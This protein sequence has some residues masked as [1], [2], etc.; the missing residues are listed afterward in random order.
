MKKEHLP[1]NAKRVFTGV[2]FDVYQWD[3]K[4]YDGSTKPFEVVA[5]RDTVV[6]IPVIGNKILIQHEQ[7]PQREETVIAPPGGRRDEDEEPLA[8]AKRELLEETGYTADTWELWRTEYPH[9][10]II[11]TIYTFIARDCHA[12]QKQ[13][14]DGGEKITPKL[15]T[16]DEFLML[17]DNPAFGE[18]HLIPTL[19]RAR[20]DAEQREELYKIIFGEKK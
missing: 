2:I 9:N 11:Y 7:Q 13:Q 20:L 6:V 1:P 14:L 15:I 4:M 12:V 16:F 19:L 3:Q 17:S 8:A 18:K 10:K 5:R